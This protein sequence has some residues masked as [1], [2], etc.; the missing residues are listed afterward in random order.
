MIGTTAAAEVSASE[1]VMVELEEL[2][3]DRAVSRVA[4]EA[5]EERKLGST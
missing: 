5:G 2:T 4:T 3:R 1:K